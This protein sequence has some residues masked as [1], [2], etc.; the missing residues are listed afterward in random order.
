MSWYID[1]DE[2]NKIYLWIRSILPL[3]FEMDQIS[4][5]I[6]SHLLQKTINISYPEDISRIVTAK[7]IIIVFGAG[8]SLEKDVDRAEKIGLTRDIPIFVSDGASSYLLEVGIIPT[9]I[10]TD[11]DGN[12]EDIE[13]LSRFGIHIFVHAHGD[14]INELYNVLKFKGY[15]I[16][17]TQ[18]EPRPYVYNFGGFTDG[19]RAIYIAYGLGVKRFILGGMNFSDPIG[20]YSIIRKHKDLR[21]KLMKLSIAKKLILR[22]IEKGVEMYSLSNTGI[23]NIKPIS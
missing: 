1:R 16:G 13:Y 6:L 18:V 8:P 11:L 12:L 14:N 22:L 2:W 19:D 10:V 17:T 3:N 5:E 4:T 15:I 20:K 21:I 9:A 23:D 7:G